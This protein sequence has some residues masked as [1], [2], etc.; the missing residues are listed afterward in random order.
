MTFWANRPHR[1]YCHYRRYCLFLIFLM[2]VYN[3]TTK[4]I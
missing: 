2:F 1:L 3:L 4:L